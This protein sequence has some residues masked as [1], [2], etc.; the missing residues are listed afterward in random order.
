MTA[1][2]YIAGTVA[3]IASLMVIT[4][5]NAVHALLYMIV[6]LFGAA[7]VFYSIGAP[8][9]A[10]L[11]V[12]VYA[13]AIMVLFIFVIMMLNLGKKSEE[14]ERQWLEPKMWI[15]PVILA[16]ILG[17]EFVYMVSTGHVTPMG[18]TAVEPKEVG[19][20]MFT[21]YM[22]G[23]ELAGMLLLAGLVGAYHLGKKA[24]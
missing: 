12:I 8:F 22:F 2:F 7:I 20:S 18:S 1:V 19:I 14:Q 4:R 15:G 16:V 9:V 3:I 5:T 10:A 23:V 6:S 24:R 21:T 17:A 13:G 11:E